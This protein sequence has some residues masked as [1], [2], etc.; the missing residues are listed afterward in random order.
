M[1]I[2]PDVLATALVDLMPSYSELFTSWHPLFQ[3][4]V[5]KGQIERKVLQG[6]FREFAVVTA[7]PGQVT[8]ITTGSEVIA[9]GRTQAA[10]RG[11]AFAPRLIYAF[12]VPGKDLSEANGEMDLARII[13]HYPELAMSDLHERISQQLASGNGAGVGG[14]VTLNGDTTYDPGAPGGVRQGAIQLRTI[15]GQVAQGNTVFG[16]NQGT[17]TGWHNQFGQCTSFATNGR[18]VMRQV[19]LQCARQQKT[20]GAPDL[21]MGDE[22]S[23][24]NYLEDLDTQVRIV[25]DTTEGGDRAPKLIRRGIKFLDSDFYLEDSITL[26][27]P[28]FLAANGAV[29]AG[30]PPVSGGLIYMLNTNTWHGFTMGHDSQLET[31][32]DFAVRGPFRLPEQ[33]LFRYEIVLSMGINTTQLRCNGA[34]VGT[35]I[36]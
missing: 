28:P 9:G 30:A 34:V 4:M 7:G 15:A 25:T 1:A 33:D 18:S 21:L 12:D 13:Q 29:I 31:T 23:Y 6:P 22:L 19:Y 26:T 16:L 11:N 32:G 36:P 35:A 3:K 2:S 20:M 8:Q 27:D 17:V 14:F 5:E 10:T 24:L